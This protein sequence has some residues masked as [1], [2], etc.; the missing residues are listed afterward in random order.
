MRRASS[1]SEKLDAD[2]TV[3]AR[4]LAG[5]GV[6][7]GDRVGMVLRPTLR[8]VVAML[9]ILKAGAAFVPLDYTAAPPPARSRA[10][11]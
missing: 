2:S 9:G 4:R 7:P 11:R 8:R 1:P 3:L 6:R 10:R 5:L